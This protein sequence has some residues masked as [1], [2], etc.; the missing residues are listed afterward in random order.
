MVGKEDGEG[1]SD[2]QF[3]QKGVDEHESRVWS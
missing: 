2:E 1:M 3:E